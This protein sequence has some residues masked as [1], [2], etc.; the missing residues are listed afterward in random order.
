MRLVLFAAFAA[1]AGCASLK[2]ATRD[3]FERASQLVWEAYGASCPA[4]KVT[5]ELPS[6]CINGWMEHGQCY[7][8]QYLST[9]NEITVVAK[10]GERPSQTALAHELL[11]AA[12]ECIHRDSDSAHMSDLWGWIPEDVSI[13]LARR[14]L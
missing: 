14:G 2:V 10:I 7:S 12:F 9:R 4:P 11:H 8:G 6:T 5:L 13:A 1:A 3:P